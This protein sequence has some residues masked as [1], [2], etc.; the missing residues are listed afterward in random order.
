MGEYEVTARADDG[1]C[2]WA[3]EFCYTGNP[4][5]EVSLVLYGGGGVLVGRA[6]HADGTPF[7]GFAYAYVGGH[8]RHGATTPL[9]PTPTD[10]EGRFRLQALPEGEVD[11]SLVK[12]EVLQSVFAHV[13]VP[14]VE[15]RVFVVEDGLELREGTVVADD[16]GEA[17]VGAWISCDTRVAEPRRRYVC[18]T[19]TDAAGA[20]SVYMAAPGAGT[21]A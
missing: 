16:T 15:E 12:P 6:V 18:V 21:Y 11:L 13:A 3:R 5:T 9:R 17:I 4:H 2:A 10:E 1:A 8:P 14:Q 20:F 7:R 19:E